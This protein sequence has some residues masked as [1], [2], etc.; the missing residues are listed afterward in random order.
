[1]N[2]N[3]FSN[4]I[5]FTIIVGSDSLADMGMEEEFR[6]G[7]KRRGFDDNVERFL[8]DSVNYLLNNVANFY[9]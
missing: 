8:L 5:V 6:F 7:W 1:M 2:R 4:S 3:S 9:P